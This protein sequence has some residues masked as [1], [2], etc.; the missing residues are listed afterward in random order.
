MGFLGVDGSGKG[1]W[2]VEG[3]KLGPGTADREPH[4]LWEPACPG[5]ALSVE[6]R[7]GRGPSQRR[8]CRRCR[9]GEAARHAQR[10]DRNLHGKG[11]QR[12]RAVLKATGK[13]S[14][15]MGETFFKSQVV[16]FF[17]FVCF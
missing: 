9:Q 12:Q 5:P 10:S 11:K 3:R 1:V 7:V 14:K 16:C 15:C 4:G 13:F 8:K 6:L 17:W 2:K